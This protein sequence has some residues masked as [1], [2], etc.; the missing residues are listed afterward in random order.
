[1]AAGAKA[2]LIM[3]EKAPMTIEMLRLFMLELDMV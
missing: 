3:G 2:A 1:V